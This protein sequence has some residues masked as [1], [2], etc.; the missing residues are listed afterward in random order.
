MPTNEDIIYLAGIIDG[1]GCIR[2]NNSSR[3]HV[4]NT[5]KILIDW[6]YETFGGYVWS[7]N[8]SYIPNAKPRFIWEV[9]ANKLIPILRQ[10]APYLKIKK[11][12]A[13]LVLYN[14]DEDEPRCELKKGLQE[15][16]H[17]GVINAFT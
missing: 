15:L 17:K 1:E 14:Y 5:S 10:V 11:E 6:L 16:N 13:Y 12:Q 2:C 7:E 3:L 9:S 4:T 8:K